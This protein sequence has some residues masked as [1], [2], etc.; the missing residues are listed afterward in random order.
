MC[1]NNAGHVRAVFFTRVNIKVKYKTRQ[2]SKKG[3]KVKRDGTTD[4][5]KSNL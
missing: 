4:N 2:K 3:C 5:V 1:V